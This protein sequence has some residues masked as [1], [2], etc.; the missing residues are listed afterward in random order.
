MSDRAS[1]SASRV[2]VSASVSLVTEV[3]QRAALLGVPARVIRETGGNRLRVAVAG[4]SG[5]DLAIDDAE[6]AWSGAI[7]EVFAMKVV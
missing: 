2:V 7:E 6:R 4:H 5:V 1:T 3:L